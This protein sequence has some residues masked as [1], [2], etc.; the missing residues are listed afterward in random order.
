MVNITEIKEKITVFDYFY[1]NLKFRYVGKK[2]IEHYFLSQ[3]EKSPSLSVNSEKNIWFHH[4]LAVGGDVF[5]AVQ[6]FEKI[7]SFKEQCEFLLKMYVKSYQINFVETENE[8]K[9]IKILNVID[10]ITD[11]KLLAYAQKRGISVFCDNLKEIH[12][13]NNLKKYYGLGFKNK[14]GGYDIRNEF[15]KGKIG[16]TDITVGHFGQFCDDLKTL[17]FEGFTDLLAYRK[18]N[19]IDFKYIV[20]NSTANTQKAIDF[21]KKEHY[22]NIFLFLDNDQA[23]DHATK[24]IMNLDCCIDM[25]Q[26]YKSSKDVAEHYLKAKK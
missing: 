9:G 3:N 5:K 17:V 6:I 15:F 24:K 2:G 21:L 4:S 22:N 20:L 13:L 19:K 12:F 11:K 1:S 18:N 16:K 7:P 14:S 23:G 8:K 25:R 10:I 26:N